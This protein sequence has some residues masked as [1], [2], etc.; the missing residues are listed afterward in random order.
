MRGLAE[1]LPGPGGALAH[2]AWGPSDAEFARAVGTAELDLASALRD[3]W[4]AL[5]DLRQPAGDALRA[6]LRGELRHPRSPA[7][8]ARLV[9]VLGELSLLC[10]EGVADGGP[11]CTMLEVQRT[12]LDSS[13]AYRAYQARLEAMER[14]LAPEL[15]LTSRTEPEPIEGPAAAM[16]A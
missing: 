13:V 4:R 1:A 11:R 5:R 9:R 10:Y 8:C 6:A 2:L 16:A 3:C 12:A 14:A 7:L 15:G